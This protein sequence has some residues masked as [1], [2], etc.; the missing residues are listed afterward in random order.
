M[1]KKYILLD[2]AM[3]TQLQ[4]GGLPPGAIPEI[5]GMQH[6]EIVEEIHRRNIRAGSEVI[7]TN[8][9]GANRLKLEGSGISVEE[10]VR[11]NVEAAKRSVRGTSV[12]IALD[13][14]PSGALLKPLGTMAFEEAVD[15]FREIVTAG[16]AAGAD[17]VIFETFTDLY[18]M[19]AAVLAAREN[20][21]LPVW[22]T[23][24]FE[25]NGRTFLG[26]DAA[27]MAMTLE[28]L[29]VSALGINCSLGPAEILPI[30]REMRRWT[31]L[32][33]IIKPNAG[34]PDPRTGAYA[35]GAEE[36]AGEMVP[37]L[38]MGVRYLG[39]CCGTTP[40][41]VRALA[42]RSRAVSEMAGAPESAA[43]SEYASPECRGICSASKV[44]VL[45]GRV[46]VI[47]ERINPT[48]KKRF[49]QALRSRD[50]N[51][52]T[53]L[54]IQQQEA[55]ADILDIN[56]GVPG[57]PEAELMA[58]VV[59]AVQSVTDL[60]LQIDSTNPEAVEAGLRVLNGRGI[61]NSV[62]GEKEKQDQILPIV[63]KYGAAVVG[64]AMD[65]KGLPKTAEDRV[66]VA[67]H[68]LDACGAYGIPR[69]DVFIDCLTLTVSA[70]QDQ[71]METL[72]AVERIHRELGL[73]CVLGVSNISFGLPARAH[74]TASFLT[75]AMYCGLDLPI[76]N[77]N[78]KA[79]MDAVASF[80]ALSGADENC[81]A[82][83]ERFA[84]EERAAKAEGRSGGGSTGHDGTS[85]ESG[86]STGQHGGG[87][88]GHDGT[89]TGLNGAPGRSAGGEA[90]AARMMEAVLK[91]RKR[92]AER[93]TRDF[94]SAGT[95]GMEIIDRMIIPALD[96][97]GDRY[98]TGEIFLPQLI[99]AAN[100][101]CA[102]LDLI[103]AGL[104]EQEAAENRGTILIATVQGDIH[105][106]GKNIVKVVLENYGY[107]IIDLGRDVKPETIVETARREHVGLVGLSA[108]MTTT[109]GAMRR[110][111]EA[112]HEADLPCRIMV[113]GAVMTADFAKEIGADYYVADAKASCDVAKKVLG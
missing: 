57:L 70:Q 54:A 93:L 110:T 86:G 83:I 34:L 53:E 24:S 65:E 11:A 95:P 9:F 19:K 94:L 12:K 103:K 36:F 92:E 46:N 31:G 6:P 13:I 56:V 74:V 7:Y 111:I 52:V 26:T 64:L 113:G 102:G 17:L 97:V 72:R 32:P 51:Y 43:A 22:T 39:G 25:E 15:V 108:L 29:G 23:M 18:E 48:G 90:D 99:N 106:I 84:E 40:D 42:N 104:Q 87:S 1:Q 71:A 67:R 96:V 100:A 112:I 109:V 33:M 91:G 49:Q 8:T 78:Q 60:P 44:T 5:W 98:E 79:I 3:G 50:M 82:Y 105:D 10:V 107:R 14:G 28:G 30:A 88:T 101:A 35:I 37:F 75:Q 47:G 2:S 62:N 58:E 41:F 76:I 77:P 81:S 20:T 80:R 68:I 73:H 59:Q 16:E 89:S 21:K 38:K 55:G 69:A 66:R 27:A 45:D 4:A 85:T 63:K 61:V